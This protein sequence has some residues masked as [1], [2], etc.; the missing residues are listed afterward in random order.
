MRFNP[1]K[2]WVEGVGPKSHFLMK[3][4]T[5]KVMMFN[6]RMMIDVVLRSPQLRTCCEPRFEQTKG[7][8]KTKFTH[9]LYVPAFLFPN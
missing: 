8:N 2:F 6:I 7:T 4:L 1:I 3:P 9:S 5:L